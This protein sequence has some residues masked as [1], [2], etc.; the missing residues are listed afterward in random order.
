MTKKVLA[1]L[2]SCVLMAT[3]LISCSGATTE[4]ATAKKE[5]EVTLV[6]SVFDANAIKAFDKLNL[7]ERF[8]E[9]HPGVTVEFEQYKGTENYSEA[10]KIR[11]SAGELPDVMMMKSSE[12]PNFADYFI[13]MKDMPAAAN[14][15]YTEDYAQNG[16]VVGLATTSTGCY[17]YYWEDMFKEAGVEVPQTWNGFLQVCIDLRDYYIQKDPNFISLCVGAKDIWPTYPFAEYIPSLV[18]GDGNVWSTMATLDEPF[19]EGTDLYDGYKKVHELFTLGVS[20]TDPLGVGHE[21]LSSLFKAKKAGMISI[22]SGL[23]TQIQQEGMDTTDLATFYV[24]I[25][26]TTDEPYNIMT[27]G[28]EFL[29]IPKDGKNIELAKEFVEFYLSDDF[30]LE[31]LNTLNTGSATKSVDRPLDPVFEKANE[32]AGDDLQLVPIIGANKAF[33]DIA[34]ATMFS[35]KQFGAEMFVPGYD[36][37]S[38]MTEWN[39]EWKDA[40]TSL[41]L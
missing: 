7:V 35:C 26:E 17:V 15:L 23:L 30:Y 37:D 22:H 13:D 38:K 32:S 39:K 12:F 34:A 9:L 28:D 33:T 3:L 27:M 18:S 16:K 2:L 40:K 19:I 14:N 4:E 36:F 41:G 1:L 8:K 24:P 5:E 29:S 25:R 21:Q 11:A 31:F 10:M 20:G 6:F